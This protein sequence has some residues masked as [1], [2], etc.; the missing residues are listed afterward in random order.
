MT[1]SNLQITI[2][3][4]GQAV[5]ARDSAALQCLRLQSRS[6]HLVPSEPKVTC[7]WHAGKVQH[8]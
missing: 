8:S 6:P 2:F 3:N 5:L 4:T 1:L 7:M